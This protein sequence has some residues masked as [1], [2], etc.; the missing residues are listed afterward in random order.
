[1]HITRDG[2]FTFT[3]EADELS[4]G[5][6]PYANSPRNQK[7][8]VECEGAVGFEGALQTVQNL[9]ELLIDTSI[10]ADGFP[11]PQLF[12]FT[13]HI[14]VCGLI[15]VYE[16][17]AGALVHRITVPPGIRWSA[18]DFHDFIYMSN[19]KV[20]IT[21]RASDGIYSISTLPIATAIC[22]FNGQVM[23][24]APDVEW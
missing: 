19:G 1:M 22:D 21:R 17:V 13:N 12:I 18:V 24:G 5:L 14:I 11:F 2:S 20:S 10:I 9:N 6:R 15:N 16:Y 4:R 7:Y 23:V 3:I 8:L